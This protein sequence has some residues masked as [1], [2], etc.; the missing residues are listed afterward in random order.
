ML[1]QSHDGQINLL[2]ALPSA[3]KEGHFNGLCA[4]GGQ[5]VDCYWKDGKVTQY[6]IRDQ[7]Q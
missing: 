7:H 2:P 1:L 5:V 3:W 6:A 4:R